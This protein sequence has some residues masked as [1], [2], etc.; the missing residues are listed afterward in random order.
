LVRFESIEGFE[1]H[2]LNINIVNKILLAVNAVLIVAV[3]GLYAMQFNGDKT[4]VVEEVKQVQLLDSSE[5]IE[6]VLIEE[7]IDLTEEPSVNVVEDVLLVNEFSP[8]EKVAFVDFDRIN[9]EWDYFKRESARIEK[10][11][12]KEMLALS[13]RKDKFK[14]EY[15]NYV[16]N[17]QNG[18]IQ[19]P[20]KEEYLM[21]EEGLIGQT[22]QRLMSSAQGEISKANSDG[23]LKMKKILKVFAEKNQIK[24]IIATGL[25]IASPVLYN[26]ASLDVTTQVIKT[27]NIK[28][29]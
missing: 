18:G 23:M 29:K 12:E 3:I 5:V 17:M 10:A 16:T 27:L 20:S 19:D 9:L 14:S 7:A 24:Y 4:P 15:T 21:K 6:A 8:V 28:Y 25:N 13:T 11:H 22:E 26:Q 1:S 2:V